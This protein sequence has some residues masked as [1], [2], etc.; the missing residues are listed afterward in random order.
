MDFDTA[1][2]SDACPTI[3][4]FE[5]EHFSAH[6]RFLFYLFQIVTEIRSLHTH[7][8]DFYTIFA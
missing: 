1:T 6:L 2:L 3:D 7:T 4:N 8:Y 5:T